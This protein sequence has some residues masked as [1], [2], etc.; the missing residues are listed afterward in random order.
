MYQTGEG[1]WYCKNHL[2]S[3][4]EICLTCELWFDVN[5]M[6]WVSEDGGYY[7]EQHA[8]EEKEEEQI[9]ENIKIYIEGMKSWI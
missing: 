4:Y 7:C 9:E 3:G 1:L 8:P 2:P 6:V 5:D